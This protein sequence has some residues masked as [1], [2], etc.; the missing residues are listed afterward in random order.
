MIFNDLFFRSG[1]KKLRYNLRCVQ[2][3]T[4]LG[5][6]PHTLFPKINNNNSSYGLTVPPPLHGIAPPPGLAY[7]FPF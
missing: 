2:I 7:Y 3:P 6:Q 5:L 4:R 1:V